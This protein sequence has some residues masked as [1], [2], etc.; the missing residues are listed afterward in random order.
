MRPGSALAGVL[1]AHLAALATDSWWATALT[2][3]ALM[4]LLALATWRA[5]GPTPAA[6]WF[7]AVGLSWLGDLLLLPPYGG[8]AASGRPL[9]LAGLAAFLLAH[10]AYVVRAGQV[11]GGRWGLSPK[12]LAAGLGLVALVQAAAGAWAVPLGMRLAV[13]AYSLAIAAML[14]QAWSLAAERSGYRDAA[15][16]ATL[17]V[18]SDALIGASV[19]GPVD[20]G[21]WATRAAIMTLYVTGQ[22]R[23]RALA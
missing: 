7:A 17:F 6:G 19:F 11:R 12:R 9:F 2:K 22:W 1:V 13:A 4:P 10:V 20:A 21:A 3:A 15:L 23:L 8:G 14:L 16:G 18:L 5:L